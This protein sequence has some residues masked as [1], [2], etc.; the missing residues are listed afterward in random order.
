MIYKFIG[1]IYTE[2][3]RAFIKIPFNVWEETG[4]KGNIP[5]RVSILDFS[6]ECKLI[7]KGNGNYLIPI[8]KKMLS[9]LEAE[10][11][12]EIGMEPIETLSRINH[13]SLLW[14]SIFVTLVAKKYH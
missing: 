6:F 13:D 12:Y 14:S 11:E 10:K 8:T 3:V 5:C 7:P 1:G 9:S 2:G 4:I